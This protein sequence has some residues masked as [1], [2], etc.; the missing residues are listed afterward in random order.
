MAAR[1]VAPV[2]AAAMAVTAFAAVATSIYIHFHELRYDEE[3]YMHT[4]QASK[5]IH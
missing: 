3:L 2:L 5:P 1:G 4:T